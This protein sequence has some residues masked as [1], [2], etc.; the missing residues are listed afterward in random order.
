MNLGFVYAGQGSQKPGMGQD[1]YHQY[2]VFRNTLDSLDP[3]GEIRDLAFNSP[4]E[5]LSQTENTQKT[6]VAFGIALTELL[7]D[8]G[9][10][11]CAA[12][13]LS[14]GE[15]TALYAGGAFTAPAAVDLVSYR[16]QVMA[17]AAQGCDS[18]MVAV[19]KGDIEMIKE[20][21][22]AAES[23]G[24]V[25]V[26][27]YNCPEQTVIGGEAQAVDKAVELI[28]EGGARRCIPLAV[29]GPFHTPIMNPAAAAMAEK[30]A[31][32]EFNPLS[33]PVFFNV[34]GKKLAPGESIPGLLTKQ[35]KSPVHFTDIIKGLAQE[36]ID[37]LV[38]IGPGKV[39]SGFIKKTE[40]A[41]KTYP[42]EDI[43]S[44][45]KLLEAMKEMEN[46]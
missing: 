8:L 4:M 31:G 37:A 1:L 38:E 43:P 13:G 14:L 16:G 17:K 30:L 33:I 15:Y 24:I 28:M 42:V 12:A 2:P 21:C 36:N 45:E 32:V 6:M 44:L 11:P 5:V 7:S 46:E 26:A 29:S 34:T 20:G 35:V 41:I 40:P 25:G 3:T 23:L 22:K 10:S 9:F 19:L 18:K 27:N 39:L